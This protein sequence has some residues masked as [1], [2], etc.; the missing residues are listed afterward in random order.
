MAS[1]KA[2]LLENAEMFDQED[3]H[4]ENKVSNQLLHPYVTL[5]HVLFRMAAIISY[6][7]CGWFSDSFIFSFVF[8]VLM[9]SA[10]FW[11]VKNIT[12]R[13]LVGLRWW[14]YVDDKGVSNWIFETKGQSSSNLNYAEKQIFW[15]ALIACPIVWT[16]FFVIAMFGLKFKWMLLVL[17]ALVL[18]GANLYGYIKCKFGVTADIST[19]TTNFVKRQVLKKAVNFMASKNNDPVNGTSRDNEQPNPQSI[20]T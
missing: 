2:P 12:G 17:I 4:Q 8:V 16:G 15:I 3:I 6:L 1:V 19:T 9:L 13:L 18:N 14:N 5:F 11:T 7:L 10:D 20:N